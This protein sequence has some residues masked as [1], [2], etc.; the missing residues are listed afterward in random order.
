MRLYQKLT[1]SLLALVLLLGGAPLLAER[2]ASS[3]QIGAQENPKIIAQF[4]GTVSD[5]ALAEYVSK[6][7]QSLVLHTEESHE[8]WT[9]TILDSPVVNAFALP[10]GYVYVTRGLLALANN[11]AELAAVLGH[12]IGHVISGHGEERIKKGNRAGI[13][14]ILGTILG[15]VFGGQDGAADAIELGAKLA[16]GYLAQHSQAQEMEADLMGIHLLTQAGYDP[17][18]Q[19]NFLEQLAANEALELLVVGEHY[20]PNRVD[21]F[22]SHPATGKR[23]AKAKSLASKTKEPSGENALNEE[24]YLSSIDGLVYGD[25][26]RE[27]FIRGQSFSHPILKFTFTV[28]T[29]FILTNYSD[30]VEASNKAGAK[31]ILSGDQNWGG[32]MDRFIVD[33]W[34]PSIALE[35]GTSNMREVR[36]TNINGLDAAIG[37]VDIATPDGLRIAQLTAIRFNDSIIRLAA[38]TKKSD[39]KSRNKLNTASQSFRKLSADEAASLKPFYLRMHKVQA[40]DTIQKLSSTMPLTGFREGQFKAMNGYSDGSVMQVGDLV[41]IIE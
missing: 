7:G 36:L 19:A 12:E 4:G 27:G 37:F 25:A 32:P 16:T 21:F 31:F 33:R 34:L 17:L 3:D 15:G 23:I 26:A 5:S 29:G 41:K 13:G 39:G 11:E 20:Y 9:F 10:G 2:A 1:L 18:A 14:V 40:G 30:R 24:V 22:A 8:S 28:P 6:I 35:F 38:L